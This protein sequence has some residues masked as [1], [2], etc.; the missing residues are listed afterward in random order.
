M[1]LKIDSIEDC[2]LEQEYSVKFFVHLESELF[3][4]EF[5]IQLELNQENLQLFSFISE[6]VRHQYLRC[7]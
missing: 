5:N 4:I 6:N 3:V 2:V 7:T 1:Q